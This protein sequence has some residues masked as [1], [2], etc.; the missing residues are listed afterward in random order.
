MST[1]LI[2]GATSGIGRAACK[3]FAQRGGQA[4]KIVAVGRRE[5]LLAEVASEIESYGAQAM[6][7]SCDVSNRAEI[8][9]AIGSLSGE[10]ADV[11]ILVNNAGLA[12]S[13][14]GKIHEQEIDDWEQMINVNCKGLMYVTKAVLPGMVERA[15]GHVVNIGSVAGN[16][17]LPM[18]NVYCA[19]KAFVNHLSLAM[20]ADLYGTGVRVTSIEPGN[21]ETEFS[22]VK[23]GG[24]KS[25]ADK[26][27]EV[28]SGQRAAM[29]GDDIAEI[30]HFCSVGIGKHVNINR[31]EM[32][33]ERQGLGPFVFDRS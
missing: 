1:V 32:M 5:N 15:N 20:R 30:V 25:K 21:T 12:L 9:D 29:T 7:L 17:A 4:T 10:W 18:N 23:F 8:T 13:G 11:D 27:Y 3:L 6:T 14:P 31:I 24:D 19:S 28:G 16:Y 26:V 33:P 2:T 22:I